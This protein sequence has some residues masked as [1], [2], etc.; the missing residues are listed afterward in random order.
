MSAADKKSIQRMLDDVRRAM[1]QC[2]ASEKD[3]LEAVLSEADGW[4]DR[5]RELDEYEPEEKK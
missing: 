2:S 5:L 4:K 3:T 1:G